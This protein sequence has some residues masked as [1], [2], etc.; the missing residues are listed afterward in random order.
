[1]GNP[2]LVLLADGSGDGFCRCSGEGLG[3][4]LRLRLAL[5]EIARVKKKSEES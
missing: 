2:L 1:M 3:G 5:L 4:P